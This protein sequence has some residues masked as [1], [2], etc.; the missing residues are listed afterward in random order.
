MSDEQDSKNWTPKQHIDRA[1][2]LV[3]RAEGDYAE[4][5][6]YLCDIARTH[7]EIAQAKMTGGRR[8]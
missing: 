4:T 2:Q 6:Q 1:C 5:S 7:A 3:D 8:A